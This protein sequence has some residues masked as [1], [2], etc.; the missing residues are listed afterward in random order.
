MSYQHLAVCN[1]TGSVVNSYLTHEELIS[2][3][4]TVFLPG[5]WS[6]RLWHCT[7]PSS[8]SSSSLFLAASALVFSLIYFAIVFFFFCFVF[9]QSY[10]PFDLRLGCLVIVFFVL[11]I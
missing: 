10:I 6:Y 5:P 9:P 7:L 1:S 4:Q 2:R 3:P 11:T 8:L